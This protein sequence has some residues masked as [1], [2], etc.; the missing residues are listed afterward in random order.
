MLPITD[1]TDYWVKFNL[2]ISNKMKCPK[3]FKNIILDAI[4]RDLIHTRQNLL[5][6]KEKKT[7]IKTKTKTTATKPQIN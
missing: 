2:K 1:F 6:S 4:G 5:A 3:Y 7:K